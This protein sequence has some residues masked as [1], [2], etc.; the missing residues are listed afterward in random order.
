MKQRQIETIDHRIVLN[1]IW[2][3][4]KCLTFAQKSGAAGNENVAIVIET[5]NGVIGSSSVINDPFKFGKWLLSMGGGVDSL[6]ISILK[7]SESLYPDKIF[8]RSI[9]IFLVPKIECSVIVA[10]TVIER[11][12][13]KNVTFGFTEKEK[14]TETPSIYWSHNI[15][16][17]QHIP[18]CRSKSCRYFP[19]STSNEAW[20]L[21]YNIMAFM[22]S[23]VCV[24]CNTKIIKKNFKFK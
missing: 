18:D 8:W 22:I 4:M 2:I 7:S 3:W 15:Q 21:L 17:Q 19:F 12:K 6:I 11:K 24:R 9:W 1:M 5:L 20:S 16:I 13:R 23:F 10:S 14:F